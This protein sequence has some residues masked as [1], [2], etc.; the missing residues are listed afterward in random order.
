MSVCSVVV[1]VV[2]LVKCIVINI[3]TTVYVPD[4]IL[5]VYEW[6]DDYELV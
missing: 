3:H 6:T 4:T 1:V 2:A 5:A